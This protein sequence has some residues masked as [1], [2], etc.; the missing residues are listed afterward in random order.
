MSV[1]EH[2]FRREQK[3]SDA[4]Q[5]A[6]DK[7]RGPRPVVMRRRSSDWSGE[8][9]DPA[10]DSIWTA[11]REVITN[12]SARS[13]RAP[14]ATAAS[15]AERTRSSKNRKARSPGRARP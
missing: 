15:V 5:T 14:T 7:A 3:A 4:A 11:Q 13:R 8:P 6:A 2:T 12:T 10:E 9:R 1:D